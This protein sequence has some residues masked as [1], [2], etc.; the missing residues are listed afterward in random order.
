MIPDGIAMVS[1]HIGSLGLADIP[2]ETSM[3]HI[4]KTLASGSLISI[5][6]LVDVD[7]EAHFDNKE[8]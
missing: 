7:F 5:D 4:F 8:C 1:T 6:H 2:P 3:A